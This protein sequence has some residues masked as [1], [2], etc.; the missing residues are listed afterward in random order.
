M[1]TRVF[2]FHARSQVERVL[3]LCDGDVAKT[4]QYLVGNKNATNDTAADSGDII[5]RNGRNPV[6]DHFTPALNPIGIQTRNK[7]T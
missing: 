7:T 3:H 1:L 5:T 2:P 4:V 6:N